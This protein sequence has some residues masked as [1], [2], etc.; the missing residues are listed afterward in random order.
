MRGTEAEAVEGQL[1]GPSPTTSFTP[2]AASDLI[3]NSNKHP[4]HERSSEEIVDNTLALRA[5]E[6]P[7][8]ADR[9]LGS[10]YGAVVERVKVSV[11]A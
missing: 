3:F 6:T 1:I 9:G 10:S 7:S 8:L 11:F 4:R 2:P 5:I